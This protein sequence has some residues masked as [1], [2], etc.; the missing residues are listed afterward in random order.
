MENQLV[1]IVDN[2]LGANNEARQQS[3]RD[4]KEARS[5]TAQQFLEALIHVSTT[6]AE[7]PKAIFTLLMLKKM[8]LDD[9]GEEEGLWKP[10]NDQIVIIKDTVSKSINFETNSIALLR[11]KAEVIC[12]CFKKLETYDEM[13]QNLIQLLKQDQSQPNVVKQKQFALY[14]FEL[15]SEY[16][17]DEEFVVKHS[18]EFIQLFTSTLEDSSIVIKVA[19]LKAISIFLGS[20]D[21]SDEVLK[22]KGLMEGLLTVVIEVM[23]E[24]ET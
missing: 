3:E 7:E 10:T 12:K 19:A 20:I 5:S 22:F 16:H 11:R 23:K 6:V 14:N 18:S 13:I 2:C 8:F 1:Q 24:D 9:R 21:D 15:L 4:M 17:L